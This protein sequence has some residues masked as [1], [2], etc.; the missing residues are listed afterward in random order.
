MIA[1]PTR[2]D[3]QLTLHYFSR[4][5]RELPK[6]YQEKWEQSRFSKIAVHQGHQLDTER[7]TNGHPTSKSASWPRKR[8]PKT[9]SDFCQRGRNRIRK[10]KKGKKNRQQ[11]VTS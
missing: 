7:P 5:K 9:L 4:S 8:P 11:K 3:R 1:I 10:G 6:K 2:G